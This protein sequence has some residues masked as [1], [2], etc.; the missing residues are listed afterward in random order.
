MITSKDYEK[1]KQDI[2]NLLIFIMELEANKTDEIKTC[3][4]IEK[5]NLPL[6]CLDALIQYA[7]NHEYSQLYLT[8][9]KKKEQLNGFIQTNNFEF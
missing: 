4:R 9:L 2:F 6:V 5:I 7:I 3:K 8:A 1:Y